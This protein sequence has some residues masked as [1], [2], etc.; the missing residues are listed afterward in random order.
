M[1]SGKQLKRLLFFLCICRFFDTA[2][3]ITK[4]ASESQ[5]EFL[6]NKQLSD[7]AKL[8]T[9]NDA[10]THRYLHAKPDSAFRLA[11]L[12]YNL[13]KKKGIKKHMAIALN[14]LGLSL[15]FRG[16][17]AHAIEYF[18]RSINMCEEIGNDLQIASVL[19]N[20]GMV[21][22][23]QK[24]YATAIQYYNYSLSK[25]EKSGDQR[26][27][28]LTLDNIG[29]LHSQQGNYTRAIDYHNRSLKITKE[30]GDS[31]TTAIVL[32]NIGYTYYRLGKLSKAMEYYTQSREIN[33]IL[34]DK[35]LSAYLNCNTGGIYYDQ[36]M[37]E[38]ALEYGIKAFQIADE[39]GLA[40]E[41]MDAAFLLYKIYKKQNQHAKALGMHELYMT[42]KDSVESE[43]SRMELIRQEFKYNYEKQQAVKDAAYKNELQNQKLM[44]SAAEERGR[45]WLVIAVIGM[46]TLLML[47]MILIL[48]HQ[49]KRKQQEAAFEKK[50]LELEQKT[51]R[52]RMNPHF[53]FNSLNAIQKLYLEG[54]RE[55]ADNYMGDFGQLLRIILDNS[56]KEKITLY[57]E[58]ETLRLYLTLEQSRMANRLNYDL[59]I[60]EE[61]DIH[62]IWIPPLIL[63][64]IVE[65]AIW[66]GIVPKNEKGD[67]Y[68]SCKIASTELLECVVEDNGIGYNSHQN[69][70][71]SMARLYSVNR[72]EHDS[73]GMVLTEQRLGI[74]NAIK[75]ED[76][77]PSGTRVTI[78]IPWSNTKRT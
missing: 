66:H 28:A 36:G 4:P 7:T 30:L 48:R 29:I 9:L 24:E 2:E 58:L 44:A 8:N 43:T 47:I 59:N 12:Q 77:E 19:S 76:L 3:A 54:K 67:I 64:P 69:G 70:K 56:G 17:Y 52:A 13:A 63:Q 49:N 35:Q 10:I 16:D 31:L 11:Q 50:K 46:L 20:I 65:N 26:E 51:L 22:S 72:G 39:N 15:Y 41:K 55:Q 71:N 38:K 14:T 57:E 60:N 6:K 27:I 74:P 1:V 5:W 62:H 53:I 34:S 23:A 45:M 75:V 33:N 21:Y 32:H 37:P 78:W 40:I 18:R 42:M 68:V 61:L 73:K 25:Q